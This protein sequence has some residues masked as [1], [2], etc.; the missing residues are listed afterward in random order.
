MSTKFTDIL[1]VD[2]NEHILNVIEDY[3][4]LFGFH[5]EKASN[6]VEALTKIKE[7][8]FDILLTDID[9]PVMNGIE[10]IKSINEQDM[11][12]LTIF[13][14][15]GSGMHDLNDGVHYWA[16]NG[17]M[18]ERI[19]DEHCLADRPIEGRHQRY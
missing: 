2:D 9:M 5:V 18:I 17:E 15:T 11:K 10:L 12:G 7:H 6:G 19:L 1:I 13:V 8:D 3:F 16:V 4:S 14:M